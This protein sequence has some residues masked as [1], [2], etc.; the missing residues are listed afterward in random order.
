MGVAY[1]APL[2]AQLEVMVREQTIDPRD[3]DLLL[4][5][6]DVETALAYVNER[7]VKPFGLTARRVRRASKVL[8]ES[9]LPDRV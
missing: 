7:T 3:L 6:D 9:A 5:T 8:G 1:W 2:R 4:V